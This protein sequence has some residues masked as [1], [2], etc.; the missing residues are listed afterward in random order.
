[1]L[2][3]HKIGGAPAVQ[4]R[5]RPT[6]RGD[7]HERLEPRPESPSTA[8]RANVFGQLELLFGKSRLKPKP[9]R[10]P[11]TLEDRPRGGRC[12]TLAYRTSQLPSGRHPRHGFPA[13]RTPETI[14]PTHA[15]KEI[16]TGGLKREPLVGFL[17]RARVVDPADGTDCVLNHPNILSLRERSGSP[18]MGNFG[19]SFC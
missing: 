7:C 18:I 15:P 14:R 13:G 1:M 3:R 17:E 6:N 5:N 16:H 19:Y 10:L 11:R 4:S 9:H 12:L 2:S 8:E